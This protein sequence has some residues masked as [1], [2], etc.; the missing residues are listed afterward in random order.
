MKD[1]F[2]PKT[3]SHNLRITNPLVVP[4]V[5]TTNYGIKSLSYQGPKIWNSLPDEIKTA[6]NTKHFKNLIKTWFLANKCECSFCA[7]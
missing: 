4:K 5:R 7:K 1:Y 3:M 2:V 6:Q